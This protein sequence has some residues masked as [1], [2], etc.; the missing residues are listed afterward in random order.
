MYL[1]FCLRTVLLS[2]SII[3]ISEIVLYCVGGLHKYQSLRRSIGEAPWLVLTPGKCLL[4][5]YIALRAARRCCVG[6][7]VSL[8]SLFLI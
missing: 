2:L 1:F 3:V 8:I 7:L 5:P 4:C 6:F